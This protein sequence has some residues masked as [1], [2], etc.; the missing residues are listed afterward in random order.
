LPNPWAS[1]RCPWLGIWDVVRHGLIAV[2]KPCGGPAVLVLGRRGR[3]AVGTRGLHIW[4]ERTGG[5]EKG[6]PRNFP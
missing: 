1:I 3:S 5:L 4:D 6:A 2:L